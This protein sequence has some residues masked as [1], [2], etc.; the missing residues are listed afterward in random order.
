MDYLCDL[1][2]DSEREAALN[3]LPPDLYSS[4]ERILD[5]VNQ[6]GPSIQRLVQRT[7]KWV[8]L[9]RERLSVP[10]LR[11]AL[12]VEQ[13]DTILEKGRLPG[14]SAILRH[15]SSLIRKSANGLYI[16]PAHFTVKEYLERIP[17]GNKELSRYRI[18]RTDTN[19]YLA[20]VCVTYL[21]LD[22]FGHFETLL[23]VQHRLDNHPF[24]RHAVESWMYYARGHFG[25]VD[26][27][28]LIRKLMK[29][30]KSNKFLTWLHDYIWTEPY[31]RSSEFV[32]EDNWMQFT[33]SV[34]PL[35]CA[36][37][38]RIPSLIEWLVSEGVATNGMSV[39][40]SPLHCAIL[41]IDV[42]T[43]AMDEASN[44][45]LF[46]SLD[47]PGTPLTRL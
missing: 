11:E 7:L 3:D 31:L 10:A 41:G 20:V 32:L 8:I 26:L 23:Y 22:D 25:N 1:A 39:V 17:L 36:A 13:G 37:F 47:A 27:M 29:P 14:E 21:S 19:L 43:S 33:E 45:D 12:A 28:Q 15:C 44:N 46:D 6:K 30:E 18:E 9:S 35:H 2:T 16:E 24:R 5:R 42:F 40:G 38:L 34:T 4:Y